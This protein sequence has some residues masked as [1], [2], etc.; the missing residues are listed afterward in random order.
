[1]L[2]RLALLFM[3]VLLLSAC[4][5]TQPT[6]P[7]DGHIANTPTYESLVNH[8]NERVKKFRGIN[9]G[10]SI[11][12]RW[13]D[14]DG[15]HFESCLAE[16]WIKLPDKT[17]MNIQKLGERLMWL[18]SSGD[19]AWVMTFSK[20]EKVLYVYGNDERREED[21]PTRLPIEPSL[22]LKMLGLSK[23][24]IPEN[25]KSK[26]VDFD[27]KRDAWILSIEEQ[28]KQRSLRLYFDRE[29][30]LPIRIEYLSADG[31]IQMYS[32]LLLRRYDTVE[33]VGLIPGTQP[34]FPTL[35]DIYNTQGSV[36]IKLAL[37]QPVD[38]VKDH[39][40]ELDWIIRTFKPDR[41]EREVQ[42]PATP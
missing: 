29:K 11:E 41:I 26:L 2:A 25:A 33:M 6:D 13:T 38:D 22:L 9:A 24:T 34:R 28:H 16:V 8:H 12:M 42:E 32:E 10:G 36:A 1:M 35:V 4:K 15:D 37:R 23:I 7:R 27:A 17:A 40:F 39:F 18:G 3:V 31:K 5:S 14:D 21:S 30:K 20:E 19:D